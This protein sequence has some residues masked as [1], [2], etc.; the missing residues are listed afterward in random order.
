MDPAGDLMSAGR[1]KT[2]AFMRPKLDCYKEFLKGGNF[3]QAAKLVMPPWTYS[4]MLQL[5]NNLYA[6][7]TECKVK[8]LYNRWGGVPRYVLY[9]ANNDDQQQE[10]ES[11][12]DKCSKFPLSA[13]VQISAERRVST[14]DF[15]DKVI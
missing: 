15:S 11:A 4:E 1:C 9:Y 3:I 5:R 8:Q 6:H 7:L 14:D 2:V 13:V 10:L 12:I